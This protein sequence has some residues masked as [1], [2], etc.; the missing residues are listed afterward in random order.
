MNIAP[1]P[2]SSGENI[3][4]WARRHSMWARRTVPLKGVGT[5][6]EETERGIIINARPED[7]MTYSFRVLSIG[8]RTVRI[9]KGQLIDRYTAL[10]SGPGVTV[11]EREIEF[12]DPGAGVTTT[13]TLY[14]YWRPVDQWFQESVTGNPVMTAAEFS[15][16]DTSA[17][18][19]AAEGFKIA[20]CAVTT[21][22]VV[23]TQFHAGNLVR[24]EEMEGTVIMYA[25][26]PG[27]TSAVGS[28]PTGWE[29]LFNGVQRF[30]TTGGA[31][32]TTITTGGPSAGTPVSLPS[33]TDIQP[34]ASGS[35]YS[36]DCTP[37]WAQF[38][39]LRKL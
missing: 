31:G 23:V 24:I 26:E 20:E 22:S 4:E 18:H 14:A 6:L 2:P 1:P 17:Y 39:L 11:N 7:E 27:E 9:N 29:I 10:G 32:T 15:A 13:H 16:D 19:D 33:G 37:P 38:M 30:I 21:N 28:P 5:Q 35:G 8:G 36:E 12:A 34:Y 3:L 25:S